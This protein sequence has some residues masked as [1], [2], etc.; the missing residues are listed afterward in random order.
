V[1][2]KNKVEAFPASQKIAGKKINLTLN[3]QEWFLVL[4][5]FLN[6]ANS[7]SP[8]GFLAN[9]TFKSAS[10]ALAIFTLAIASKSKLSQRKL[11]PTT[12]ALFLLLLA[13]EAAPW[14]FWSPPNQRVNLFLAFALTGLSFFLQNQ[15]RQSGAIAILFWV[16]ILNISMALLFRNY[17]V[18]FDGRHRLVGLTHPIMLAFDCLVVILVVFQNLLAGRLSG[19][20]A[21]SYL[22]VIAIAS[23]VL[24][25]TSSRQILLVTPLGLLVLYIIEKRHSRSSKFLIFA[26]ILF[27]VWLAFNF[28]SFLD[29]SFGESR[30]SIFTATGRTLIWSNLASAGGI[31]GLFGFGFAPISDGYGVDQYLFAA[32]NGQ[33]AENSWLQILLAGGY[34]GLIT[35]V[36]LI[37]TLLKVSTSVSERRGFQAALS[38]GLIVISF[39]NN[40]LADGILFW[41]LYALSQESLTSVEAKVKSEQG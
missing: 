28:N 36:I 13:C 6:L 1:S 7:N 22:L 16:S 9:S 19:S 31:R 33:S 27:L 5:I 38:G 10:M 30:N 4:A 18:W 2:I 14:F 39:V 35:W 26:L 41:W 20:R 25:E 40:G 29:Q 32:T 23:Y 3:W 37:G 11:L 17:A 8:I 24:F 34:I 21:F 15:R 12:I